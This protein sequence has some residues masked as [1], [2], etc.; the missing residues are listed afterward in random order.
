MAK[1]FD[2]CEFWLPP[3]FLTDDLTLLNNNPKND[4]VFD[5]VLKARFPYLSSPEESVVDSSET[6]SEEEEL[7]AELTRRMA[8][9]TLQLGFPTENQKVRNSKQL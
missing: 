7:M 2:D 8:H 3:H 4:D 1:N 9:S 5:A 6:E